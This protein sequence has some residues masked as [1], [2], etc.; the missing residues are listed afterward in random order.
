[1]AAF[2]QEGRY[3]AEIIEQ[4]FSEASTG[5]VQ[6]VLCIKV[7]ETENGDPVQENSRYVFRTITDKTMPYLLDDLRT[8]GYN[9]STLSQ[10]DPER[11]EHHSFVGQTHLFFCKHEYDQ[12]G[13]SKERWNLYRGGGS[14]EMKP[15]DGKKLRDLDAV[16]GR[17]AKN[18]PVKSAPPPP[19]NFGDPLDSDVPM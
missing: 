18:K 15:P 16:F 14:I 10:L 8:L 19:A 12:Q 2:Y 4:A 13:Q 5:N 9:G 11:A 6:F 3:K 17:A 7:F 1:M